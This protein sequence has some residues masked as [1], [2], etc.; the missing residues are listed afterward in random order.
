MKLVNPEL[1]SR[2]CEV[3]GKANVGVVRPGVRGTFDYEALPEEGSY[4]RFRFSKHSINGNEESGE[5]YH[6]S[7]MFC[8]D[9]KRRLYFNHCWGMVN[10]YTGK[11]ILWPVHCYNE[12]CQNDF[13]NR[14]TLADLL[15]NDKALTLRLPDVA[16][17]PPP[18]R[19]A[20]LPGV[21]V[22]LDTLAMTQFN[23]PAVQWCLGR[24]Y[25]PI[26]LG[27]LYGVS[28]CFQ[29]EQHSRKAHNRVV[30][31]FY[32]RS[33]DEIKLAGW[34]ARKIFGHDE[35]DKWVHSAT[36]T[37]TIVYGLAEASQHKTVVV[38]EGPGDKWAVGPQACAMLGK[39]PQESKLERIAKSVMK[40]A[41]SETCIVILLDPMQPSVDRRL[42]K[43]HHILKAADALRVKVTV[44]VIPVFLPSFADPGSLDRDMCWYYIEQA[45]LRQGVAIKRSKYEC[46]DREARL[47]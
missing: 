39:N 28:F 22:R 15:L 25:N 46:F 32:V 36:P 18:P 35:G 37:K 6:T 38:V 23:H 21:M 7:C 10:K 5:E 29:A 13:N 31:P 4:A 19:F 27:S 17:T 45:C 43:Q 16:Y 33:G 34:T 2:L 9:R 3:F 8:G 20:R 1:Y 26:E 24:G 42:G 41:T 40:V 11:P 14:V 30:A 12:E 44:P 47:R